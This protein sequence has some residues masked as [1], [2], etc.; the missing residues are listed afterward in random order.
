VQV[1]EG[2]IPSDILRTGV[3]TSGSGQITVDGG[4]AVTVAGGLALVHTGLDAVTATDPRTWPTAALAE[5]L[6]GLEAAASHLDATR[7]AVLG[8]FDALAGGAD[9][10]SRSTVSWLRGHLNVSLN[11]AGRRVR[12]ARA[13]PVLPLVAAA[14]T[15]GEISHGHAEVITGL[16]RGGNEAPPE[17]LSPIEEML[18]EA[19]KVTDPTRLFNAT[20]HLREQLTDRA[21]DK[22]NDDADRNGEPRPDPVDRNRFTAVTSLNGRVHLDGDLDPVNG[23][24]LIAAVAAEEQRLFRNSTHRDGMT[25]TQRRAAAL[26]ALIRR[27]SAAPGAPK[28]HG[29]APHL[30]IIADLAAVLGH[31]G[32]PAART[33]TGAALAKEALSRLV[34]D[35]IVTRVLM[36]GGSH[37][38]DLGRSTRLFSDAQDLAMTIRDGGCVGIGCNE[39]PD[40]C[41]NHH[42]IP[43]TAGGTTDVINGA[44]LCDHE[45]RLVH[46]HGWTLHRSDNPALRA[47]WGA[48]DSDTRD[49]WIWTRPDGKTYT[50][51]V[52][53]APSITLPD[54]G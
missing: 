53:P 22:A 48:I 9:D 31:P 21:H 43:W 35:P 15:A 3:R 34:C 1:L 17:A 47:T 44:K 19:A 50:R 8:A 42:L 24:E 10:G 38:L 12:V 26:M 52:G 32:A 18:V 49:T 27:A 13:L 46:E 54:T 30:M 39:P 2:D 40:R 20:A 23:A 5:A 25:A 11:D 29:Q 14:L 37:I 51:P 45:H 7:A 28:S 16:A 4:E 36:N 33:Q 41:E 6:R